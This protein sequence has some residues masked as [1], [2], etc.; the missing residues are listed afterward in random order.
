MMG[1]GQRTRFPGRASERRWQRGQY[2]RLGCRRTLHVMCA[3]RVR[4]VVGVGVSTVAMY[5]HTEALQ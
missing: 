4:D 3:R 1:P 2:R 5:S